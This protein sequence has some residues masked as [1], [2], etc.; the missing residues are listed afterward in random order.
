MDSVK[1]FQFLWWR[2]KLLLVWRIRTQTKTCKKF[3]ASI[4]EWQHT[5]AEPLKRL[6]C[7]TYEVLHIELWQHVSLEFLSRIFHLCKQGD[8]GNKSRELRTRMKRRVIENIML[9]REI[10]RQIRAGS[11]SDSESSP[12]VLKGE[13][14]SP[15]HTHTHTHTHGWEAEEVGLWI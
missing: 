8:S 14:I 6:I 1:N 2:I 15:H 5:L 4:F 7:R 10:H 9:W 3:K 13:A 11:G 12:R